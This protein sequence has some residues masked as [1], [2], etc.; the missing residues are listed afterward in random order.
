[1]SVPSHAGKSLAGAAHP[2]QVTITAWVAPGSASAA[3]AVLKVRTFDTIARMDSLRGLSGFVGAINQ[4][5]I[6]ELR[7][8]ADISDPLHAT[9]IGSPLHSHN[10]GAQ[11]AFSPDGKTLASGSDNGSVLLWDISDRAHPVAIGD[12]LMPP[13]VASRTRVAFDPQ[14]H[15]Y[16]VRKDGTI[17]I[18]NL[19]TD[20]TKRICAGTRNVL[21]EQRWNQVPPSVP[22]N[23]PCQ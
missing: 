20:D 15:L 2:I 23:P 6:V 17:R 7:A 21:T 8:G 11:V 19:E 13:E 18:F 3:R 10:G 16:A 14:G 5:A 4:V 9:L 22:Y 1:M 12:S